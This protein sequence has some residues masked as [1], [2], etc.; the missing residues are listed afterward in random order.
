[1]AS[2]GRGLVLE[3]AVLA[4]GRVGNGLGWPWPGLTRGLMT[5]HGLV[6]SW[7]VL[8]MVRA[9]HVLA[10]TSQGIGWECTGMFMGCSGLT[11]N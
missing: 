6:C 10:W 2:Y 9:G 1:M 4:I 7:S 11:K 5:G 8:S 3:S